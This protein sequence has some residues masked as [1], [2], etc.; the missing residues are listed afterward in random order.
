MTRSSILTEPVQLPDGTTRDLGDLLAG[1]VGL[2]VNVASKCGLT[3]QYAALQALQEE[4]AGA[5]LTVVGFPCNQF[6][7]QEPGTEDE[8][9]EFCSATYGTTFPMAA[10]VAVNGRH[11][12]PLWAVLTTAEDAAGKAGEVLWNFEKFLVDRTGQVVARF[13]PL[14]DPGGPEIRAAVQQALA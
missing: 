9:Q 3:P 1:G 10:K 13:R 12:D 14:T 8:I 4:F 5:G 2:V 6:G 7:G 11:A